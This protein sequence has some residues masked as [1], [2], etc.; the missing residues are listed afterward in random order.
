[1]HIV[2]KGLLVAAVAMLAFVAVGTPARAQAEK[3]IADI[4]V[5][6]TTA[7]TPEFTTLL[8][9]VQAADPAILAALSNPEGNY[10]VFAPTDAAFAAAFQTLNM[11]PEQVLA[12]KA[13]LNR[14][15]MYHVVPNAFDAAYFTSAKTLPALLGT[16]ERDTALTIALADGKVKVND[17]TVVTAD[18]KASNGVVHVIDAVLVPSSGDGMMM[19]TPEA[20]AEAGMMEMKNL[21]ETVIGA[22]TAA[23]PE[24]TVLLAAVQAADPAFLSTLSAGGPVTVF[25]PTDAAFTALLAQ[26]N[27][28]AAGLLA[29]KDLLNRVL[30]YHVVPG[31]I[32]A[33][34]VVALGS[35]QGGANVLTFI[36]QTVNIKVM[37]GKV[38]L[39]DTINV[40][41]TDIMGTNGIVHVIDAVLVPAE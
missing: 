11:T 1:M 16:L 24:F 31:Y 19:A 15:L 14:V 36:P 35:A 23:T 25:A 4:V 32:S 37:D 10:T 39:N 9:A 17:A 8:A 21:A 27:T 5:E 2:R 29:N 33:K 3:T 41:Q 13:L 26:L 28:D 6:S 20:T 18:I 34:T 22:T 30:A 7:A 40:V 38:M 12:D